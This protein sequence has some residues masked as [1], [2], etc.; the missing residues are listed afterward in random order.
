VV[1]G[2]GQRC[3][4]HRAENAISKPRAGQNL[5]MADLDP[6]RPDAAHPLDAGNEL[7]TDLDLL[8]RHVGAVVLAAGEVEIQLMLLAAELIGGE[9]GVI[10]ANGQTPATLMD[11][12]QRLAVPPLAPADL[13]DS[14]R[15]HVKGADDVL[16]KRHDV[17]HGRWFHTESLRTH[18]VRLRRGAAVTQVWT[19]S[20]VADLR[21]NL[22]NLAGDLALDSENLSRFKSGSDALLP[23]RGTWPMAPDRPSTAVLMR[24]EPGAVAA[25]AL[26]QHLG[27]TSPC[28]T[29]W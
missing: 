1:I 24:H 15:D 26:P 29:Q 2:S 3:V 25:L 23:E 4:R 16:K 10:L 27:R 8:H 19:P 21:Q 5:R 6:D 9:S 20:L 18:T 22:I 28:V 7:L 14:I 13:A 12:C 17:A 11:W